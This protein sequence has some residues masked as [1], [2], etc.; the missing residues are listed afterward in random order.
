[1]LK[2][3]TKSALRSFGY[4]FRRYQ[5]PVPSRLR[6]FLRAWSRLIPPPT[7]I[8]DVGANHGVWTRSASSIFP[9]AKFLM[10]EPQ[11]RL[12]S[13]ARDLL[14]QPRLR[15]LTAGIS[16]QPGTM[17]LTLPPRD[18]SATFRF[19]EAAAQARG[20][21][22]VE[23]PVTTLDAIV[24][25]EGQIPELV[26]IDAE[27]FDLKALRGASRLLGTTEVFFVE[28]GICTLEF[29]NTLQAVCSFMWE[30]GYRVADFTGLNQSPK[31]GVLWLSEVAFVRESSPVWAKLL[32]YE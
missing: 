12:Q 22:Q 5:A 10:V 3:L 2:N 28:C 19:S 29:E 17:K 1:M 30:K 27:G 21:P 24:T 25:Q 32:S 20:Y 23:V 11:E 18:D 26:K 13:Y 7:F 8:I 6:A 31:Y 15:W 4:E 14:Q 9:T 16:D